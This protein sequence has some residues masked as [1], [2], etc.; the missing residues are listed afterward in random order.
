MNEIHGGSA[1][2]AG[3]FIDLDFFYFYFNIFM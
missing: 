3:M 1:Y 2:G